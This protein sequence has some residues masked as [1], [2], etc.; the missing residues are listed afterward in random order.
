VKNLI[1]A[2]TNEEKQRLE[3]FIFEINKVESLEGLTGWKYTD[4]IPRG[5]N[6]SNFNLNSL[7]AYLIGRKEK[8][9]YKEIERQ[10]NRINTVANAG[11]L[12]SVKITVEWKRN[13]TWG[14]NPT[15]EAWCIF[16]DKDGN[17]NSHYVKSGSIGGCGY[18][19]GSTAVS[20]CLNQFNEV[21]K[22]L[23]TEKEK[24]VTAKNH[25]ILG[26][27]S[28]YGILPSVE[29][30][31]GVSCYP[32]IFKNVGFEFKTIASGKSFDAYSIEKIKK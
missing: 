2:V 31:V 21:L 32:T 28:G 17:Q 24:N 4:L 30:G 15:A 10:V 9:I 26:Y 8:A 16:I 13:R 5:K 12:V 27:G 29:G 11:D 23:Y 6:L 14:A 3:N 20:E 25:E 18:D 7:R 1:K 22:L 19:K